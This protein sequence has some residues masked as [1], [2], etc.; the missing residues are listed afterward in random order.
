[1][2]KF[3]EYTIELPYPPD[4][5]I[6][7]YQA[8]SD[9]GYQ[10]WW[11]DIKAVTSAFLNNSQYCDRDVRPENIIIVGEGIFH[12]LIEVELPDMI[13]ELKMERKFKSRGRKSVWQVIAV[14]E[15]PWPKQNLK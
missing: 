15:K 12:G 8:E 9:S 11:T 2:N 14:K 13:L 5:D 4:K 3:E 7:Y 10:P 1:M 6:L